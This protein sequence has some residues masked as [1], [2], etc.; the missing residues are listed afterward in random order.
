MGKIYVCMYNVYTLYIH[1][2]L[3]IKYIYNLYIFLLCIF[4]YIC[5]YIIF[6]I[7]IFFSLLRLNLKTLHMLSVYSNTELYPPNLRMHILILSI[8]M[9]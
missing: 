4:Y 2:V 5:T 8:H 3:Y 9:H 7:Y 6:C 1:Y